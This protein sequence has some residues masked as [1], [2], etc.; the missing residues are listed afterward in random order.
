MIDDRP[1]TA[2]EETLDYAFRPSLLG[3]PWEFSLRGQSLDWRAGRKSG[4][5]ALRDIYRVRLSFRPGTMQ[6]QRF[7]AEIW[8]PGAPKL[9]ICSSS[10]KGLADQS[11]LGRA[12]A[13][14]VVEL[15]RRLAATRSP[16]RFEH[17]SNPLLYWPGAA[18]FAG[19]AIGM[20]VL[21]VSTLRENAGAG[22]G[23]VA[24]LLVFLWQAGNYFRRNRPGE[25]R[26]DALPA[27]LM[28]RL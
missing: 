23:F 27:E 22:A 8:A 28:P 5:V 15:H 1:A 14:F 16:V 18:V 19:V 12:Y 6:N 4:A 13:I 3:A 2:G 9:Q 24:V 10:G 7:L 26:P 25:Y 11:E 21:A 20:A 17:G